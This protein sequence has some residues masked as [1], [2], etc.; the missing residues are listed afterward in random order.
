[1]SS[2]RVK[3]SRVS[4]KRFSVSRRRSLYLETPAASSKNKRNS[5]GRDSMMRLIVPWPMMA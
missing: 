4:D 2:T 1:M 5:S 3:F